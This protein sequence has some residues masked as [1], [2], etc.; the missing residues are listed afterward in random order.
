MVILA[1]GLVLGVRIWNNIHDHFKPNSDRPCPSV[2]SDLWKPNS[3]LWDE[4]KINIFFEDLFK[5]NILN[6]PVMN[7]NLEYTLCWTHTPDAE[8][9]TERVH[10]K[11]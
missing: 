4:D 5:N 10:T 1:I 11:L 7:T 8:C 9:T 6:V 3:K 2:V